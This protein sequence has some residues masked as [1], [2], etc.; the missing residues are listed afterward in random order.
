MPESEP[1]KQKRKTPQLLIGVAL[2]LGGCAAAWFYALKPLAQTL[3]ARDWPTVPCLI[4]SAEIEEHHT[5]DG[6]TWSFNIEYQYTW[7]NRSYVSDRYAFVPTPSGS[8]ESAQRTVTAYLHDQNP[9]CYVNPEEPAQAVLKRGLH[10]GLF[11]ALIP[12]LLLGIGILAITTALAPPRPRPHTLKTTDDWLPH[13]K[14]AP[15]SDLDNQFPV[16][17]RASHGIAAPLGLLA[18]TCF[19]IIVLF[20]FLVQVYE[21]LASDI[22]MKNPVAAPIFT[23]VTLLLALLTI[24]FTLKLFNPRITLHLSAARIPLGSTAL[25]RW[26]LQGRTSAVTRLT[27]SLC[28]RERIHYSDGDSSTTQTKTFYETK[29]LDTDNYARIAAGQIELHAPADLMHSFDVPD[30]SIIWDLVVTGKV[31]FFPDF[32]NQF[33]LAIVP[34]S[35]LQDTA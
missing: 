22:P 16:T 4:L 21:R 26:S 1:V 35:P 25:L 28:G 32:T 34:P 12:F 29:L 6:A 8:R 23:L 31:E 5:D 33:T 27:I 11:I 24:H 10:K 2:V 17:L 20:H 14:T 19:A 30:N 9:L 15:A 7:Q 3:D 13:I 18:A